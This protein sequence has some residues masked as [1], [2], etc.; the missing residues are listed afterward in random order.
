M[1]QSDINQTS[2]TCTIAIASLLPLIHRRAEEESGTLCA[3][4][5]NAR[6]VE[7]SQTI[8]KLTWGNAN[9]FN[10]PSVSDNAPCSMQ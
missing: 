10:P 7:I 6:T 8:D 3:S 5:T 4:G 1:F 9:L 2:F